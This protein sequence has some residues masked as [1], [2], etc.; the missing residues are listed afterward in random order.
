MKLLR[1]AIAAALALGPV[2]S[3]AG[4]KAVVAGSTGGGSG[5]VT[6][7]TSGTPNV[8]LT[9]STITSSGTIGT[10]APLNAQGAAA[11]YTIQSSDITKTITHNNGSSAVAD[12]LPNAAT[13]GFGN[14]AQFCIKNLGTGT[15]TVT[16]N[17]PATIDGGSSQAIIGGAFSCPISDGTNYNTISGFGL[18]STIPVA[19]GGTG[20]TSGTSGGV[21]AYTASGTL[22]SSGALTANRIVLGGGAG[23]APT[24]LG[25]L[26]TTTTLLHG[27]AS[28]APSFSSVSLVNDITGTLG[29][30][31]GGTG[32]TSAQGNGTKVQL[33]TGTTTLNDCVKFDANGNTVDAGSAC[34]SGGASGGGTLNYSDNGVT[35][36][37]NTYFTPPGGGGIPQTTEANVDVAAPSALTVTNLQVSVSAAPGAG[38]SYAITF[39]D[40][41]SDTAVTC[42]I[43]GASATSCS[44]LTHSV[45][46][47]QGDLI[48][49]KIVSAGTIVTTPTLTITSNNGTSNVGVTSIATNNGITGGTISTTGT[50]GL[51]SVSN[52]SVLCNN[53]GG[54]AVPTAANCTVTGTGNAVLAASPTVTGTL[55]AQNVTAS[56]AGVFGSVALSVSGGAIATDASLGNHFRVTPT[57]SASTTMSAP[58]NPTDGQKITY[59]LVQDSTGSGTISWNAVFNFGGSGAPT[60]TTTANKRDLVGF[61]YSSDAVKWLYL[62]SQLNF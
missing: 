19:N 6:S 62:G 59:E 38:N 51:A 16:P 7:L 10:T 32:V 11:T 12:T 37:A 52:N 34:G 33:S 3:Y 61:V 27:N 53:T 49:W 40:A 54:S 14:G 55:T 35:L 29:V 4:L 60:L 41:G 31:N 36:T 25:S 45:N 26:G 47:A 48:D 20:I 18:N 2:E 8:V 58:T 50:I 46:V 22:A 39:R 42:T 5:T 28:G 57:H 15:V 23:A 43:S 17:S 24:V 56:K 30:A 13:S 21:L 1:I 9:P 44:D